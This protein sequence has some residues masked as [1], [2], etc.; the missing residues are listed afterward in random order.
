MILNLLPAKE[1]DIFCFAQSDHGVINHVVGKGPIAI[2]T[3]EAQF[4]I[5]EISIKDERISFYLQ[6]NLE[7]PAICVLFNDRCML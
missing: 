1:Y 2:K 4:Q 7:F 3:P 6:S 5:K